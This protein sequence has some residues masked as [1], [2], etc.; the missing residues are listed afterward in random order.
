[1]TWAHLGL[2]YVLIMQIFRKPDILHKPVQLGH[3][4]Q[5]QQRLVGSCHHLQGTSCICRKASNFLWLTWMARLVMRYLL[6][7][8]PILIGL[9]SWS[10]FLLVLC[11]LNVLLFQFHKIFLKSGR[12]HRISSWKYIAKILA[13]DLLYDPHLGFWTFLSARL[14]IVLGP[15][16]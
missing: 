16:F 13:R 1:M 14:F 10:I 11:G 8:F 12:C 3:I 5:H 6:M 15:I 2:F 9:D 7:R 4:Q